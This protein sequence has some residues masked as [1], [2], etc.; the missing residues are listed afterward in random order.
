M[1]FCVLKALNWFFFIFRAKKKHAFYLRWTSSIKI[2]IRK[3]ILFDLSRFLG[4]FVAPLKISLR[5][6]KKTPKNGLYVQRRIYFSKFSYSMFAAD[7][8]RVFSF[9]ESW[10]N[11][12]KAFKTQKPIHFFSFWGLLRSVNDCSV[13][14]LNSE[15]EKEN[16]YW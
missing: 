13:K 1:G 3:F 10:K 4:F 8:R 7:K 2:S 11:E 16:N 14:L 15:M 5:N 12:F 6:G 9:H